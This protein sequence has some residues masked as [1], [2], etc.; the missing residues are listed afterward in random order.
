MAQR[1]PPSMLVEL[2]LWPK[3][4]AQI[5]ARIAN[6]YSFMHVGEIS[7]ED[8]I[9]K[10]AAHITR[11]MHDVPNADPSRRQLN[12]TLHGGLTIA[13][14]MADYERLTGER[15]KE[16]LTDNGDPTIC[17]HYVATMPSNEWNATK[18]LEEREAL[19]AE[20]HRYGCDMF[21]DNNV[22]LAV[23]HHDEETP[24]L[25][26]LILP[27]EWKQEGRGRKPKNP[28]KLAKR[29]FKWHRNACG[30][31]GDSHNRRARLSQRQDEYHARIARFGILRGKAAKITG[32]RQEKGALRTAKLRQAAAEIEVGEKALAASR[33]RTAQ[34]LRAM[35]AR[36]RAKEAGWERSIGDE[37]SRRLAAVETAAAETKRL[38][39]DYDRQKRAAADKAVTEAVATAVSAA[40]AEIDRNGRRWLNE[41]ST[42]QK[43]VTDKVIEENRVYHAA[44]LSIASEMPRLLSFA[45]QMGYGAGVD[46]EEKLLEIQ[47]KM[48]LIE[49][50]KQ[51]AQTAVE[52]RNTLAK[53]GVP[54]LAPSP[55][56]P[57]GLTLAEQKAAA[58]DRDNEQWEREPSRD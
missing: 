58:Y 42:A 56:K 38:A 50:A 53:A 19:K 51:A 47:G 33:K 30:Y 29:K 16:G 5:A 46:L 44:A 8:G 48:G 31:L 55:E 20:M 11:D 4:K 37:T 12:Q 17:L 41:L 36:Q 9:Y 26:M 28:A 54:L 10:A 45:R 18:S 21:G 40:K 14:V 34:R 22:L 23:W 13:E 27:L 39:D 35:R 3:S 43:D 24:H 7:S 6:P 57:M 15:M 2:G 52:K 32:A 25:H 49:P 1:T